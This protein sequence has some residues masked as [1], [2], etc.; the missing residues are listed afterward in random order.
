MDFYE[1]IKGK[2]T[3]E[4][5]AS[6]LAG[7]GNTRGEYL[8]VAARVRSNQELIASLQKASDDSSYLGK[9]IVILTCALVAVGLLQAVATAWPYL[10]WWRHH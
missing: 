10:V 3:E 4:I 8:R 5:L 6:N 7:E 9:L 1:T 2:T